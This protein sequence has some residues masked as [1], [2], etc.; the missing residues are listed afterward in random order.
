MDV[1][2]DAVAQNA[3]CGASSRAKVPCK[4]QNE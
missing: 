4:L 2:D 3:L 1:Q